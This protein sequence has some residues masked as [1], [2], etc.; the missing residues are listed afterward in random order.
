MDLGSRV[1]E[2]TPSE[3]EWVLSGLS[4]GS[5]GGHFDEVQSKTPETMMAH[6]Q[7]RGIPSYFRTVVIS[8]YRADLDLDYC[9]GA[10]IK[11][12]KASCKCKHSSVSFLSRLGIEVHLEHQIIVKGVWIP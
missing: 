9:V 8:S 2:P 10:G 3:A 6:L 12:S 5:R 7:S 4:L 11:V 1:L